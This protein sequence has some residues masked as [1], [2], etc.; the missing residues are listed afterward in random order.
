M[1]H[2]VFD[3]R[4]DKIGSFRFIHAN[5]HHWV[6]YTDKLRINQDAVDD[7]Q[8]MQSANKL[9]VTQMSCGGG[10]SFDF[11]FVCGV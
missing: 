10:I 7:C 8:A 9:K 5:Y 2:V 11:D 3:C 6:K 4:V 1:R